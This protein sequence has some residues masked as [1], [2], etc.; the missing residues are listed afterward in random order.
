MTLLDRR[1]AVAPLLV[2]LIENQNKKKMAEIHLRAK[3]HR[4]LSAGTLKKFQVKAI[5]LSA[6][7]LSSTV[8][9]AELHF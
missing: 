2:I 6:T 4:F 3:A 5:D 9:V 8:K 7:G 1:K